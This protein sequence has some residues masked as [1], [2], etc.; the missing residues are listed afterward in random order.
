MP[1]RKFVVMISSTARDLPKYR[2]QVEL[3]CQRL[4]MVPRMMEHLSAMA[5]NAVEASLAMVDESDVYV[6]LFAHRYGHIPEGAQASITEMEYDRAERKG[7]PR[8]IFVIDEDAPVRKKDIDTGEKAEKLEALKK[9]LLED[10]VVAFFDNPLD[11]STKVFQSLVEFREAHRKAQETKAETGDEAPA[12]AKESEPDP[13][14]ELPP[15]P[16]LDLPPS[17]YRRL[18]WF[19]REDAGVFF[20]RGKETR[21]LYKALSEQW[22]DP[23]VLFFGESGVGKSSL[24]A[25]GVLPRLETT[26][27]VHYIR[28]DRE[29]GLAGSLAHALETDVEGIIETWKTRE[30]GLGKPLIAILDQVEELYTRPIEREGETEDDELRTLLEVLQGLFADPASRP[31]GRL[32]L[33]FRKEWVADIEARLVE[34]ALPFHKL[35]LERLNL[36]GVLEVVCGPQSSERLRKK[37]NL[38]IEEDLPEII[39]ASLLKDRQSP[40]APTLSILLAKMWEA[41]HRH[42]EARPFF[43]K[44]L[45]HELAGHGL[46]LSDFVDEQLEALKIWNADIAV[47]GLVLDVLAFHTTTLGTAEGRSFA[48]VTERYPHRKQAVSDLLQKSQEEYLLVGSGGRDGLS[49]TRLAHDTLAPLIRERH[50]ESDRPGQRAERVLQNRIPYWGDGREGPEL[51][52]TGLAEVEQGLSGMRAWDGDETRL[53][54]A[55]RKARQQRRVR[56]FTLYGMGVFVIGF[57]GWVYQYTNRHNA[58]NAAGTQYEWC[59]ACIDHKG[60]WKGAGDDVNTYCAD[61]RF[62]LPDTAGDFVEIRA[63]TF[64]MGSEDGDSDE[65]PVHEVQISKPFWMSETEVTQAWWYAV[66]GNNPSYRKGPDLPVERVSWDDVQ[67]FLDT[68]N[69]LSGCSGCFRLPTEA[70]WEYAARAGT[71]TEYSYGDDESTLGAYAWYYENSGGGTQPVREK[72]PNEWGLYDMHGNVWEWVQDWYGEYPDSSLIDPTG[73]LESSNRVF[74]GGSWGDDARGV[75]SAVRGGWLPDSRDYVVGFRLVRN[76][77]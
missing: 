62:A 57:L 11:L 70:E 12:E 35:F 2:E 75:R 37:Y 7:I 36:Q 68:L 77:P 19:R 48:E 72:R 24:L 29:R 49:S 15:L 59:R 25:A 40:V 16:A 26:H 52:E 4:D 51:D 18:Q 69:A 6:G 73:P 31:H 60:E 10:N 9:R 28:R 21:E 3:A 47:S 38:S 63:G 53:V 22:C 34:A 74:R 55:S 17:P 23:I 32:V 20:G 50:R 56:R 27:T 71:T 33:S 58:C 65:Q 76:S 14:A 64:A 43:S 5:E 41:A 45:Y 67:V 30:R 44:E 42:N 66:M 61:A 54:A 39:A 13:L 46:L 1:D 8:L